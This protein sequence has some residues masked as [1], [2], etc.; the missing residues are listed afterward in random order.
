MNEQQTPKKITIA[1]EHVQLDYDREPLGDLL[2][3]ALEVLNRPMPHPEVWLSRWAI[4]AVCNAII[5]NGEPAFPL[6]VDLR[7]SG[8]DFWKQPV[9]VPNGNSFAVETEQIEISVPKIFLRLCEEY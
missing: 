4:H 1:L 6:E 3:K 5:A 7:K 9:S 2:S 8:S